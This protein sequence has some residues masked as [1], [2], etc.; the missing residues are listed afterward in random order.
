M[1][2]TKG[3]IRVFSQSGIQTGLFSVG[4]VIAAA[5]KDDLIILL[6]HAGEPFAG[7]ETLGNY[8]I[9]GSRTKPMSA[10]YSRDITPYR[11]SELGIR[12]L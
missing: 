9:I 8:E 6:Y 1:A 5:G 10:T 7:K 3:Y 2:T 12:R 4:S 11:L